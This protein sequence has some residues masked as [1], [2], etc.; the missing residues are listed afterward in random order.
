MAHRLGG[1]A[2]AQGIAAL[3]VAVA[4]IPLM[5]FGLYTMNG[6][7]ILFWTL[8]C[9][10]L[11][12]LCRS[13]DERLW[14]LVGVVFGV[15]LENKHTAGL[16]I[17]AFGVATLATPLRSQLVR[18]WLWLGA[19]VALLIALPNLLWQVAHDAPSLEFY[20]NL[21]RESNIPVSALDVLVEQIAVTNP[22]TFPVW[23][24][25]AIFCFSG[26]G[27][28]YRPLGWVFVT[29]LVVAMAGGKSR[30]DRIAGVYPAMFAAGGVLLESLS[31][32]PHG[33]WVAYAVPALLLVTGILFAP[34]FL[35]FPPEIQERHPLAAGTND[36]RREVGAPG[37]P[38]LTSHRLGSEQFVEEVARVY[39]TLSPEEQRGTVILAGDFA[40]AGA[41]E[42]FGPAHGLPR[43]FSPHNNYFLWPPEPDLRADTVI[44][45]A[46]DEAMLRREF[47]ALEQASVYECDYCMGWRDDLPIWI[48]RSP[49]RT[50]RELWPELRRFGLPTRK[51]LM[52]QAQEGE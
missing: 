23:L 7:E 18:R 27:Q 10:L 24:A 8:A 6:F 12:E 48:A 2:L 40:H 44:A 52:L 16:L 33:R 9:W 41:I 17:A 21:D 46:V 1:G 28:R 31:H 51:L 39:G 19:L 32:R 11:I 30:P 13:G 50:L 4:P 38:I 20:R 42:H 35:P 45:I 5:F 25:G 47:G 3:S 36:A 37:I 34:L 14:L 15:A 26:R 43:V 49:R 22:G 29:L